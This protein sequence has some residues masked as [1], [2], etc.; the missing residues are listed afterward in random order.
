MLESWILHHFKKLQIER[1]Q[2][3]S[4]EIYQKIYDK[5]Y[6]LFEFINNPLNSIFENQIRG[7]KLED[8]KRKNQNKLYL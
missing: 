8:I 3:K 2:S 7:V 5:I 1:D 6:Y 4:I